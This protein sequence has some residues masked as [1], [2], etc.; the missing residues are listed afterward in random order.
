M[1]DYAEF[2]SNDKSM[3]IAPAGYGKTHTIA[4]AL[5]HTQGKGKQ[6]ILTH[7]HAGVSSIKEK[8]KKSGI[9]SSSYSVETISSFAQKLV[10]SFYTGDDIPP[11][12][13]T[14]NYYPFI[15][16]KAT[17]LIKVKPIRNVI[18]SSYKGLFVD[19]YQDCTL[20]QHKFILLLSNIFPTRILGDFMQGIF[21][22]HGETLVDMTNYEHMQ[23]FSV[24]HELLQ[25]QR[26][27]NGNNSSLGEDLKKIREHLIKGEEI[28]LSKFSSI[29]TVIIN[30]IDLNGGANVYTRSVW[31]LLNGQSVLILHPDSTSIHPRKSVIQKFPSLKLIESIDDK[32]FYDLAKEADL[33]TS[34]NVESRI[35]PLCDL[36]FN[37]TA[38][39]NWFNGTNF[40]NKTKETDKQLLAPIKSKLEELKTNMSFIGISEILKNIRK[41]P[42]MKCYRTELFNTFCKVLEESEHDGIS[43]FEAMVNK[44]NHIRR[45]GRK[46]F[47]KC[48]GTT[49]LTKG[50]EFDTVAILNAHKFNCP[51]HL[52][53][54]LTR[55]SKRL[56]IFTENK[57][58]HP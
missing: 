37:K 16:K 25:P 3:L 41:F 1:I 9:P 46:I 43:V 34:T 10:L 30:E 21:D 49:L 47:G 6:L 51:K 33:I 48:I 39:N 55:A 14:K 32:A 12:D 40:K 38:V 29:E 7:T 8:I 58:L 31:K 4:E 2:T 11:Q 28:D 36:L 57:I 50:L 27:L 13:D 56:V 22:F 35:Q 24:T 5:K 42:E 45:A 53:V 26:W 18:A 44:R 54:A 23:G 20:N 15:I 17:E 19:E 52:Y